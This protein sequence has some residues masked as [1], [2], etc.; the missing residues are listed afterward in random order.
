MIHRLLHLFN[1]HQGIIV[2]IEVDSR[3][4]WIGFQCT[5]CGDITSLCKPYSWGYREE[6]KRRKIDVD[7]P[8]ETA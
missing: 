3:E 6:M 8:S 4:Y 7:P 1:R 2:S 5:T